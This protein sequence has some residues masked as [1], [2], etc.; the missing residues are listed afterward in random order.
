MCN[1][2]DTDAQC[3]LAFSVLALLASLFGAVK[4]RSGYLIGYAIITLLT[5]CCL[6]C[7]M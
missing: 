1:V 7:L 5:R 3:T 6:D 4:R 2:A